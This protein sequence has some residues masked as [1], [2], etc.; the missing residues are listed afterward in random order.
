MNFA[1]RQADPRRHLVGIDGR[2]AVPRARRLRPRDR[3]RQEGRRGHSS[4]DR[5]QGD[6]G[7]QEAAA[8]ARG[9][10]C[11]RRPSSRRRRRRSSRRPRSRSRPRRRRSRRSPRRRRRRRRRRSPSRRHR[12]RSCAAAPAPPA[13]AG[14]RHGRRRLLELLASDGRR[15]LPARSAAPGHREGRGVDPVHAVADGRDQGHPGGQCHATPSSPA[16]ACASSASTS[17]RG[18]AA[19]SS[20][21]V[22]FGYKLE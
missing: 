1:E 13:P 8:A 12:R 18:R 21:R 6:R 20:V 22:P 4:A 19:T 17:V 11:R 9:G 7:D 5:D 14:Y 10:A 15:G 2:H 3:P 16:T